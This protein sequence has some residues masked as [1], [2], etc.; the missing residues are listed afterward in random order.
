MLQAILMTLRSIIVVL[1]IVFD[2]TNIL[3]SCGE[4]KDKKVT[5][6]ISS[7]DINRIQ[8]DTSKTAILT[9]DEK[10]NYPFENS[11]KPATLT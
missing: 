6:E 1:T 10:G 3:L 4:T 7:S 5:Q 2:L 11:Y 9:F 8:F